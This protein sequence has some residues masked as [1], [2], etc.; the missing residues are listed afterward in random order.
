MKQPFWMSVC[1]CL[2]W[3][4]GLL[5]SPVGKPKEFAELVEVKKVIPGLYLDIR[6]ATTNNFMRQAVYPVA[7]CYIRPSTAK[8]LAAAQK[9]LESMGLG[10]KI[11]DGY[12]PFSVTK[13]MW[14]LVRDERYV[15]NPAKGSKHNRG[16]ALDLTLVTKD[17][18]ELE[19]PTEYDNFTEKAHQNYS[20]LPP[21]VMKN[22]A[23][24]RSIMEKHG[25]AGASTEWWH[26]NDV[27]WKRFEVL[28]IPLE[29]LP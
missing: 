10:F 28:D 2:F 3:A 5:A 18:K 7:K 27:E 24:L 16:A 15:A 1:V 25:F 12:R 20:D 19:M 21:L 17:G 29:K 11:Y 9:E 23:L 4:K 13:Q 22:R 6:Y 14:E 8:K 26:F